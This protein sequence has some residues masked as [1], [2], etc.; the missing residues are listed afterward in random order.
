MMV[1]T[2]GAVLGLFVG[3]ILIIKK[4]EP[5]Y[6][7]MLGALVGALVGGALL[8]QSVSYMIEGTKSIIPAV[9]R[10]L[11][12]GVLAGVLIKTGAGAA[13]ADTLILKLGKRQALFSLALSAMLLTAIGVFVDITI[14]TIAPLALV[15]AQ[16]LNYSKIAILVALIGGG[17][18]G[19]II[20]PNPN[21]ISISSNLGIELSSLMSANIIPAIAGLIFSVLLAMLIIR[22]TKQKPQV[23]SNEHIDLKAL[24]SFARSITA[25]LVAI[26]LLAL[27]PIAGINIDPLI[28]LPA[29]GLVGAVALGSLSQLNEHVKYGLSKM[30]G[31]AILLLGTGAIAGI[32]K[33]SN[34]QNDLLAI[35]QYSQ[36]PMY[37]LAPFSGMLMSAATASTTA[38]ATIASAMFAPMLAHTSLNPLGSGAM[39]HCGAT[40]FDS[41]PH[42]SFF[43]ATM[44]AVGCSFAT[45][46]MVLPF[47]IMIGGFMS[48]VCILLYG[49]F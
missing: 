39:I 25:P 4:V 6:A 5:V 49:V 2:L 11:S 46:L 37:L 31:V 23:S 16:R 32:I 13:I 9:L 3:I 43:H 18:A 8:S 35:L 28:A 47:E 20:S 36:L 1:S 33:H 34:L 7:L 15:I 26:S 12:S 17:K 44:G 45:R 10:I 21:T 30:T 38:G 14:I 40:V 19:N 27:R 41:L 48:L 29:G 22:F 42:G 24:P